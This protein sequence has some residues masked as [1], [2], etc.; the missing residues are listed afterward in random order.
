MGVLRLIYHVEGLA[1]TKPLKRSKLNVQN[2]WNVR[3]MWV[4]GK[5][6]KKVGLQDPLL[7]P[8]CQ[9][10]FLELNLILILSSF[11]LDNLWLLHRAYMV[12]ILLL[13]LVKLGTHTAILCWIINRVGTE[14]LYSDV[15]LI[16]HWNTTSIFILCS[17]LIFLL[18][19]NNLPN[20]QI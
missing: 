5:K 3:S 6:K 1:N 17:V 7:L 10:Q 12:L 20:P 13:I 16:A 9:P 2:K 8:W 18:G 11:I 15:P 14:R 4:C 19:L